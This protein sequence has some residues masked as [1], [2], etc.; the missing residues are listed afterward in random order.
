MPFELQGSGDVGV[1]GLTVVSKQE[2]RGV[3]LGLIRYPWASGK[4]SRCWSADTPYFQLTVSL[5]S[6]TLYQLHAGSHPDQFREGIHNTRK[7]MWGRKRE[8]SNSLV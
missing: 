4:L 6:P 8:V 5:P 3:G 7:E 1:A 2:R